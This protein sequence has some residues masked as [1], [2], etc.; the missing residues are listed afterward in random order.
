MAELDLTRLTHVEVT[1]LWPQRETIFK[2]ERVELKDNKVVDSAGIAFLVQWAKHTPK[3]RL[4]LLHAAPNVRA[5]I[6]TFHLEPLFA[7]EG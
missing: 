5:L 6:A 7:F 1:A 2:E 3:Q 4:T